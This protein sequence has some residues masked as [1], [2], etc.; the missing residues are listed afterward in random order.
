[1]IFY[2]KNFGLTLQIMV[3]IFRRFGRN[4][5]LHPVG[6][7]VSCVLK[8]RIIYSVES[9]EMLSYASTLIIVRCSYLQV[10]GI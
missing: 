9:K 7:G 1:M 5:C 6:M 10:D 2:C 3:V 8:V 4:C